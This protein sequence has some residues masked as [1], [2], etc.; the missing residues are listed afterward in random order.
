MV[1]LKKRT[2]CRQ[3]RGC[4]W[5]FAAFAVALCVAPHPA[6]I[7]KESGSVQNAVQNDR[8]EDPKAALI[9]LKNAI[10]KSPQ[11]AALHVKI[12]RLY[13]QLGRFRVG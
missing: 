8:D 13:F 7:A 12:A 2:M 4:L 5:C 3:E 10:R 11:D 1:A 6:A 9:T